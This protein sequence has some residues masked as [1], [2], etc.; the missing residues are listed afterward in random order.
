LASS[1]KKEEGKPMSS[2][3]LLLDLINGFVIV[4]TIVVDVAVPSLR[5]FHNGRR[6]RRVDG[7]LRGL[8]THGST[9][10]TLTLLQVRK[11]LAHLLMRLMDKGVVGVA[12]RD[13]N[14]EALDK[15]VMLLALMSGN[16]GGLRS[17]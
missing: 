11:P 6:K 17:S 15:N 8:K 12:H 13:E 4:F 9:H 14:L 10:F 1:T 7:G 3:R 5:V 2:L 16:S